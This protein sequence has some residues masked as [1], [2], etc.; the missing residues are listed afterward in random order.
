[1]DGDPRALVYTV[2][3]M[4]TLLFAP[5]DV[6]REVRDV[7]AALAAASTWG[8][9][10]R[11]LRPERY[12]EMREW[13][14]ARVEPD[15]PDAEPFDHRELPGRGN[16]PRLFFSEIEGWLPRDVLDEHAVRYDGLM[17]SGMNLPAEALEPI[18]ASLEARG[19]QCAEDDALEDL[20]GGGFVD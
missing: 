19:Y 16:W 20:I 8:D 2:S 9:V 14:L 5:R 3:E 1:M 10:R 13:L 12:A 7:R 11:T 18:L 4:E 15:P 6:A 17:D